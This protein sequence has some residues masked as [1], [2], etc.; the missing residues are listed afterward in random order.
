MA[1]FSR[2]EPE[3]APR[4]GTTRRPEAAG[5]TIIAPGTTLIGDLC[6]EG[7][8]KVEGTVQ[9]TVR[10]S[11]EL[12]IGRGGIVK[13]DVYAPEVVVGGEINGGIQGQLRVEIQA[14]ALVQGDILTERIFIA[15][16]G[17]VNGQIT[18]AQENGTPAAENL[19]AGGVAAL[20]QVAS[21]IR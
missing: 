19:G 1:L 10:T 15:E 16:G 8:V 4:D 7:V 6:A 5:L 13:G 2:V 20:P 14:G 9:G 12:L 18:M 17:R 11:A 21:H 3:P